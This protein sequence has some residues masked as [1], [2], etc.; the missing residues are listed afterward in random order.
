[1]LKKY[2]KNYIKSQKELY[3]KKMLGALNAKYKNIM[4]R[5]EEKK[6]KE[7][8]EMMEDMPRLDDE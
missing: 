8:E 2:E 6:K 5:E 1:M 4:L 7:D 3:S